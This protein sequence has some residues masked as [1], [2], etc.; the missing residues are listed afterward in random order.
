MNIKN[1]VDVTNKWLKNATPN[2]HQV[3]D[4]LIIIKDK[5]KYV[6]DRKNVVLDYSKK[7]K[8]IALWI[9]NTFGGEIYMLPRVNIPWN[10]KTPDY[11][12]KNEFWDLKEI[13]SK[14]KRSIDNAIK[15]TRKQTNNYILDFSNNKITKKEIINQIIKI[16]NSKDRNWVNKIIIKRDNKVILITQRKK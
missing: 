7:E 8:E 4:S 13:S 14:G 6:V 1:Y 12:W 3:K 9:E 5:T 10:V 15:R 16:Y 11:L 2:T